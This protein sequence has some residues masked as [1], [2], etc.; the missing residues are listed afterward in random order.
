MSEGVMFLGPDELNKPHTEDF[1][2]RF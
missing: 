2:V 1:I